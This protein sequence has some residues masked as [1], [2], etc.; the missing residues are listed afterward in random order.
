M[1]VELKIKAA[2]TLLIA[3]AL[4]CGYVIGRFH[5]EWLAY[6][7]LKESQKLKKV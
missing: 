3:A 1:P 4:I 6:K 7:R 2:V 5:A